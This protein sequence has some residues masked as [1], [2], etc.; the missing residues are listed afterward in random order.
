MTS[1]DPKKSFIFD[2]AVKIIRHITCLKTSQLMSAIFYK[3]W[4]FDKFQTVEMT[5]RLLTVIDIAA[6]DR[7][8]TRFPVVCVTTCLAVLTEHECDGQIDRQTDG[9]TN[10][11][12]LFLWLALRLIS[13]HTR[14]CINYPSRSRGNRLPSIFRKMAAK[15]LW[16]QIIYH[17]S[18]CYRAKN[19]HQLWPRIHPMKHC[20]ASDKSRLQMCKQM[21]SCLKQ[22]SWRR[23]IPHVINQSI[24]QINLTS[25]KRTQ[26]PQ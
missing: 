11:R 6:F 16:I 21:Y 12:G 19:C 25:P 26:R 9:R 2:A 5:S 20:H 18:E 13:R 23:K 10:E 15:P 7:L 14:I 1:C 22:T 4:D 8:H 24:N 17:D 3:V